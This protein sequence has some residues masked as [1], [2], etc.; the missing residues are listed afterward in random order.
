M[1]TSSGYRIHEQNSRQF[2]SRYT[3]CRCARYLIS[4]IHPKPYTAT[5]LRRPRL[6]EADAVEVLLADLLW[7]NPGEARQ[8]PD[9]SIYAVARRSPHTL[10]PASLDFL[11]GERRQGAV[12]LFGNS[13]SSAGGSDARGAIRVDMSPGRSVCAEKPDCDVDQG[14]LPA[15]MPPFLPAGAV[16]G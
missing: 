5:H 16:G 11:V 6:L 13:A 2:E 15:S 10:V 4:Y 12:V 8:Q 7:G 3:Q 9:T 1:I 14:I